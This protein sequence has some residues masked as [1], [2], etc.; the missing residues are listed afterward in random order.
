MLARICL[1]IAAV[2]AG[3]LGAVGVLALP[4]T[5]FA[6]YIAVGT[7]VGAACVLYRRERRRTRS[8]PARSLVAVGAAGAAGAVAACTVVAGLVVVAGP[9][10]AVAVGLLVAVTAGWLWWRRRPGP[11]A[12]D[13]VQAHRRALLPP[14]DA[15]SA[16]PP[17]AAQ[18]LP[19]IRPGSASTQELCAAWCSSYWVLREL[20]PGPGRVQLVCI[21]EC[22]LDELERRDPAG[23]HR[24]LDTG[25]RA[26]SDPSRFLTTRN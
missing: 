12:R 23:F 21:R 8:A 10:S 9:V 16:A 17:R 1:S 5:A 14:A 4:A 6:A 19:T 24:W 7:V 25:A 3:V 11:P 15:V 18:A 26:G 13:E 20:P 2:A 22:L